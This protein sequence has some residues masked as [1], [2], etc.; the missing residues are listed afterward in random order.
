MTSFLGGAENRD[1]KRERL[2]YFSSILS[3]FL[4]AEAVKM[5]AAWV[6]S[7][8]CFSSFALRFPTGKKS[9]N[10]VR[11][12]GVASTCSKDVR[13]IWP[14]SLSEVDLSWD[15]ADGESLDFG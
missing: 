11:R 12:A 13:E 3:D 8:S 15:L 5:R 9:F 10:F 1:A 6:Q 2:H 7:S 4:S 14:L